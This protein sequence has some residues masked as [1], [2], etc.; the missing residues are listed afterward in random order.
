MDKLHIFEMRMLMRSVK[1]SDK[2]RELL[3]KNIV[4][5]DNIQ[6]SVVAYIQLMLYCTLYI[7]SFTLFD[8]I[9]AK[10]DVVCV[11]VSEGIIPAV[12]LLSS[13]ITSSKAL[14][15]VYLCKAMVETYITNA[16]DVIMGYVR[17]LYS[18]KKAGH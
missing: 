5:S 14:T 11:M 7:E 12:V 17:N 16:D 9:T 10:D 1:P 15:L 8:E 2:K 6:E 4:A 3:V 13:E 18:M